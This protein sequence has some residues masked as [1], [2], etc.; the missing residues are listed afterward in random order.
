MNNREIVYIINDLDYLI[1][2]RSSLLNYLIKKNIKLKIYSNKSKSQKTY[3][4]QK[5]LIFKRYFI[6]KNI[7]IIYDLFTFINIFL[8]ILN[9]YKKKI[10]LF[11]MKPIVLGLL[12]CLIIRK[13]NIFISISGLG[14]LFSKNNHNF[15]KSIVSIILKFSL[16]YLD[17]HFFFQQNQDYRFFNRYFFSRR[18]KYT[19]VN[20]TGVDLLRFKYVNIKNSNTLLFASR[21]LKDKGIETL[22][23]ACKILSKQN[24]I[25]NAIIAGKYVEKDPRY[26]SSKLFKEISSINNFNCSYKGNV[27]NIIDYIESS[28]IVILPT[29]YN[30]GIPRI[31]IESAA[32][33]R[34]IIAS[35][36]YGCKMIVKH[37]FNGLILNKINPN[38][39][40][41]MIKK[42]LNNKN[43]KKYFS[44]N[45][46][47]IAEKYFDENQVFHH[48]EKE[49][50]FC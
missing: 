49:Y 10:H 32:I 36:K 13:K 3:N 17:V 31:L 44:N 21:L 18:T 38:E 33:G 35:N 16:K 50:K 24:V 42:I 40:A 2:H 14:T 37:E 6:N 30:E 20:G 46:R 9:N 25:F 39:L 8:I 27:S 29:I 28:D 26:L 41:N 22:I 1:N 45:S 4:F 15:Q 7:N 12:S 48:H 34:P 19:I 47:K 43:L 11:T 5:H 23:D